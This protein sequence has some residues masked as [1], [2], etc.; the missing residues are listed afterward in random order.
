MENIILYTYIYFKKKAA[1]ILHKQ[2]KKKPVN[3]MQTMSCAPSALFFC[4]LYFW[5]TRNVVRRVY[6][7]TNLSMW[8]NSISRNGTPFRVVL[9]LCVKPV[10]L[11][12]LVSNCLHL[13]LV[14][15]YID[16]IWVRG[17]IK[18]FNEHTYKKPLNEKSRVF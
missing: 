1:R 2:Y 8:I 3:Y 7:I 5:N 14:C 9:L 12:R 18:W 4:A 17:S 13:N 15:T 10:Y 11:F 16:T 6:M